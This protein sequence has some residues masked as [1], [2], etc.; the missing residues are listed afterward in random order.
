MHFTR[1]WAIITIPS[2]RHTE[3]TQQLGE[4]TNLQGGRITRK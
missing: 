3:V 2:R 1:S 4:S